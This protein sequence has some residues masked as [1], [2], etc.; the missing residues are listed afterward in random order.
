MEVS[1]QSDALAALLP[2][3]FFRYQFMRGYLLILTIVY[4]TSSIG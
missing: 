2:E 4:I 1:G 3:T